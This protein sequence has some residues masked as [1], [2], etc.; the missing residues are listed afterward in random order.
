MS[1]HD[2]DLANAAGA[3]FRSDAN[4]ALLALVSNSSGATA[5]ATT[6][7]YQLWA[8]TT[9]GW[10]KQRNAANSAWIFVHPLAGHAE[11]SVASAT[12][13]DLGAQVSD[14]VLIS[15]TTPITGFGTADAGRIIKVRHSGVLTLTHNGTSLILPGAANITTAA[16]DTYEAE[17][18][19]SG[20]WVVR[21]Y[22]K[23]DGT[24][25]V[26]TVT[27]TPQVRQTV[28]SGPVDTSGLPA[29]GGSTGSTTVTASGTLKATAMA[30]GDANYSGS[31]TNPSWTGLSTNGTMFLYLDIT[32]GGVVTTA[33]S[34][35]EHVVQPGGTPAV[36]SGLLTTNYQEGKSYLGNGSTAPQ[37]YRVPVGEVTV[38]G[39][40][41]TAIVWYALMGI[42]TGPWVSTL[43]GASTIV[44]ANH[45]LGTKE[46][47]SDIELKCLTAEYGYSVGDIEA[48]FANWRASVGNV[49]VNMRKQRTSIASATADGSWQGQNISTASYVAFT[50]AN[51]A[52]RFKARRNF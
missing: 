45:N 41:V 39:G 13:T 19:G 47:W 11:A 8:D 49:G 21:A 27:T 12:T 20:N 32:S 44:S 31:I 35:V 10:L 37:I 4:A 23:A 24:P 25:V 42:Y 6:F 46:F 50:A 17:S 26:N 36:T 43:P 38:A 28:L 7:A 48:G 22:Q 33:S 15:G 14:L 52:Y 18:L 29:F 2:M 40:V 5:P 1:Q 3:S 34:T 16:G 51:W 9:T 30:G